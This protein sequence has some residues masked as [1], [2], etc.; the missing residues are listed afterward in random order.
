MSSKTPG[1]E[2]KADAI[3]DNASV[4]SGED[5]TAELNLIRREIIR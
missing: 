2:D 5:V 1:T 3:S 4:A